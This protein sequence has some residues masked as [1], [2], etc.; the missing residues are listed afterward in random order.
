ASPRVYALL[1]LFRGQVDC[2]CRTIVWTVRRS[3]SILARAR[4]T[5]L[6]LSGALWVRPGL[7]AGRRAV[8]PDLLRHAICRHLGSA[9]PVPCL[10]AT[11]ADAHRNRI[12]GPHAAIRPSGNRIY[13]HVR[14]WTAE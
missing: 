13:L 4:P 14:P 10:P 2:R 9:L 3:P 7:Y 1:G 8:L 11:S 12:L 6:R 5:R